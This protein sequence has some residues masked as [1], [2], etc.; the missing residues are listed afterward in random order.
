MLGERLLAEGW[1]V[2]GTS[3]REEGL[4]AIEAAGIEPA[5]ADLDRVGTVVELLGDVAILYLLL[6][7]AQG[8]ADGVAA[9]HGPRLESLMEKVVDTPV[10][11]VVYEATG[12][13]DAGLL[14]GG[15]EIVRR[16]SRTWRIPVEIVSNEQGDHERW[17][18]EMGDLALGLLSPAGKP[19]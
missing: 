9:I 12:T 10:R 14:E 19:K 1:A 6:G 8:E 17:S 16:A 4:A 7:S 11:G 5:P 3:R 18:Q 2:R 15:A 13:V